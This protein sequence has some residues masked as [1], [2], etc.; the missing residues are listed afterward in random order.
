MLLE[1]DS[2]G[3]IRSIPGTNERLGPLRKQVISPALHEAGAVHFD[4]AFLNRVNA[5]RRRRLRRAR[6]AQDVVGGKEAEEAILE[7]PSFEREFATIAGQ[8]H[9]W[10]GRACNSG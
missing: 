6:N 8:F 4:E 5:G 1:G 9:R 2:H 10:S 3:G 7:L